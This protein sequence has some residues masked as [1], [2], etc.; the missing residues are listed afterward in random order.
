MQKYYVAIILGILFLAF[1]L[2]AVRAWKA[3]ANKQEADFS[4]PPMAL[5]NAGEQL[6]KVRA[7]YVATTFADNHLERIRAYGLGI[8]GLAHA[9]VFEGGLQLI[10]KGERPL[11][12]NKS[13]IDSISTT[14]VTIDRVTEAK[15]ILTIDWAQDATKFST[16]LRVVDLDDRAKLISA[17]ET[18]REAK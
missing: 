1:V 12:I 16:H 17:L 8:R 10:R 15:G 7:Y 3:R 4:Q 2:A 5:A 18:I 11:A 14:Q 9:M 6:L 13:A